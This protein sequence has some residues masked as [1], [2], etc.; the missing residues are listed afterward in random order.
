MGRH[1]AAPLGQEVLTPVRNLRI[2]V[3]FMT[4]DHFVKLADEMVDE[5]PEELLDELNGG[6]SI[7]EGE[8]RN[9]DDPEGVY[10]LGEYIIDEYLGASIVLY[11]GSFIRLFGDDDATIEAELWETIR[12]EVRHHI[13]ERAGMDDLNREDVEELARMWEE[14]RSEEAP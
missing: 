2:G 13:E 5:I 1:P 4:F 3:R 8:R 10:I 7:E 6:I 9:E 14:S 11:Y 12:H